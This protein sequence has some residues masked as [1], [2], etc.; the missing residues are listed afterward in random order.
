MHVSL[1]TAEKRNI[2]RVSLASKWLHR[3]DS[4][5][6]ITNFVES[7]SIDTSPL[8]VGTKSASLM[9]LVKEHTRGF[10]DTNVNILKAIME[11]FIAVC[12]YHESKE[13]ILEKWIVR[14]GVELAIHKISDKKLIGSSKEVL[15]H[16][17]LVASP[18]SVIGEVVSTVKGI[19]APVVHEESLRWVDSFCS[20]FGAPSLGSEVSILVSWVVEVSCQFICLT[21]LLCLTFFA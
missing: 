15:T 17:C 16:L 9:L 19:K 20:N 3:Q 2:S 4:V 10:K 7:G 8:D 13:I 21:I 1:R 6:S 12:E 14:D 18:G 11:F 5:K